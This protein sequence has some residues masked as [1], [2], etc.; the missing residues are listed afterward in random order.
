MKH[1]MTLDT[2]LLPTYYTFTLSFIAYE[3]LSLP[4][5][6]LILN[7][8]VNILSLAPNDEEVDKNLKANGPSHGNAEEHE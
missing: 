5:F 8:V 3:I 1:F 2:Y 7:T 6:P 4:L